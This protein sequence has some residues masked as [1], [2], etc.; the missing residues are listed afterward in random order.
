MHSAEKSR[1]ESKSFA[2][3]QEKGDSFVSHKHYFRCLTIWSLPD[4]GWL[5]VNN[6]GAVFQWSGIV[7]AAD[8]IRDHSVVW[9]A[10]FSKNIGCCYVVLAK[11]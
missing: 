11:F 2:S 10:G 3:S 9:V 5:K 7:A 6:E 1:D 4:V 8:L